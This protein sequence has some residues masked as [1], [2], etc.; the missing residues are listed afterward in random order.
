MEH[1]IKTVYLLF[2]KYMSLYI[3]I[4]KTIF[5]LSHLKTTLILIW[6]Y[7]YTYIYLFGHSVIYII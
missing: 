3:K 6:D 5:P 2:S 7:N 1:D 4:M